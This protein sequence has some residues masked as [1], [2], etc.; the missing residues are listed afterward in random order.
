MTAQLTADRPVVRLRLPRRAHRGI[1]V[2][3]TLSSV[4]W[5]GV[6]LAMLTLAVSAV[7][8]GDDTMTRA[9]YRADDL[10]G[11][12]LI[13]PLG[14]TA[15]VSGVLLG[16]GSKWGLLRYWWVIVKL[17][18]TIG[19]LTAS[20]TVLRGHLDDAAAISADP[21]STGFDRLPVTLAVALAVASATY[22]LCTVISVLK[23]WGRRTTRS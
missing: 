16:V 23:P 22:T 9:A 13:V 15:A 10:V 20:L 2:V 1:L 17:V 19:G 7:A 18:L 6:T 21:A 11:D 4:A 3:H 14:L 12:L 8:T 5:L